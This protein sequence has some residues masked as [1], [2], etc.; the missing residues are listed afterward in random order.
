MPAPGSVKHRRGDRVAP[1]RGHPAALSGI[2]KILKVLTGIGIAVIVNGRHRATS[3][4]GLTQVNL[5]TASTSSTLRTYPPLLRR[6]GSTRAVR[7]IVFLHLRSPRSTSCRTSP[8]T[9]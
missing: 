8:P 7:V 1:D 6:R 9:L 5:T 4:S 2:E 3:R